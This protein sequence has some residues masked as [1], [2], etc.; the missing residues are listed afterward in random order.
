MEIRKRKEKN[1]LVISVKGRLDAVTAP[2]VEK[3]LLQTITEGE[4]R[5]VMDLSELQ[6][7]SSAGLRSLL[8]LAK[9]LKPEQGEILFTGLQ[10]PVDE[11]FKISGFYSI[12]KIYDSLDE[13]LQI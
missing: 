11:V 3:D 5:F 1:M 6:Y 12:F 2:E 4:K 10:G 9:K 7:I 13:A 8:V